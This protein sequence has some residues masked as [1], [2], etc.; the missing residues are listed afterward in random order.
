VSKVV[1]GHPEGHSE[2][3]VLHLSQETLEKSK[4]EQLPDLRFKISLLADVLKSALP[5]GKETRADRTCT[6]VC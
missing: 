6:G 2:D 1:Q 4:Q 3:W 5:Q